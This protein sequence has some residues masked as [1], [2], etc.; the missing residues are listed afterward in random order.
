[1]A[2]VADLDGA[3]ER[4]FGVGGDVGDSDIYLEGIGVVEGL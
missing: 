2:I 3:T 4:S 1:M